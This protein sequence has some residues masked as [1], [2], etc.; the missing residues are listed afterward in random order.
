MSAAGM[1]K[2]NACCRFPISAGPSGTALKHE[3]KGAPAPI[4]KRT[5]NC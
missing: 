3:Q 1:N 2:R 4:D 5:T